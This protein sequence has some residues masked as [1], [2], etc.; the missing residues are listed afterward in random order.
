VKQMKLLDCLGFENVPKT[1]Y[2]TYE[3][4]NRYWCRF[5]LNGLE[6]LHAES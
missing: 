2:G 1:R 6:P 4:R 3:S 5:Q